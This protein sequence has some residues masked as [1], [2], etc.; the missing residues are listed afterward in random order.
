[1]KG[2]PCVRC[3]KPSDD[4]HH[5]RP[6]NLNMGKGMG[7]TAHEDHYV[8]LDLCRA[9][10]DRAHMKLTRFVLSGDEK[11]VLWFDDESVAASGVR[12]LVLSPGETDEE[13]ASQWGEAQ[14]LGEAAVLKQA[15]IALKFR[16]RYGGF[17]RWWVRVA[18][19]IKQVTGLHV[20]V[21]TVYDRAALG[22][23]AQAWEG[24]TKQ[25]LGEFGI[26]A[27]AAAGRAIAKG[28]D[29]SEVFGLAQAA[30]DEG[31]RT[32]AAALIKGEG[33]DVTC[34]AHTCRTCGASW[35]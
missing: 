23:A 31:T 6:E 34:V 10:H 3:G 28:R 14:E 11:M 1:M 29:P 12:A 27:A 15:E 20:S 26:K 9:C 24:D 30:L 18:D 16:L 17:D 7:G 21:G 4:H 8:F 13:L 5:G 32:Q 19:I 2:D 22:V 25:F 35:A 33:A